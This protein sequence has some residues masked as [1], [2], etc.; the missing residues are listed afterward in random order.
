M[1]N[2]LAIAF[3]FVGVSFEKIYSQNLISNG[4]FE[5]YYSC[6]TATDQVDSVVGWFAVTQ[7]PDYFNSCSA[8]SEVSVPSNVV[9]YQVPVSGK[10]YCGMICYYST[11]N[12]REY[13]GTHL[14]NPLVVGQKYFVSFS[15]NLSGELGFIV[16]CN[17]FGCKLS[18]A[19]FIYNS[20]QPNN[21][22]NF[23]S[24]SII[25]DTANWIFIEGSFIADSSYDYI[26]FGNFF[27]DSHSDTLSLGENTQL[28]Y[29]YIDDVCLS[30]DSL[31]CNLPDDINEIS[32]EDAI[33][34]VPNP[35]TIFF[36][37][38]ATQ[39]INSVRVLNIL[40]QDIYID[41]TAVFPMQ[42]KQIETEQWNKGIYFVELQ[43]GNLVFSKKIIIQ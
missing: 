35:S 16:G 21:E 23:Y 8:I 43:I 15:L 11:P 30:S 29:Y 39:K 33:Q 34:I 2:C 31:S 26:A 13:I 20:I 10:A 22:A 32:S 27:D 41:K 5:E 40:G 7:S 1:K 14:I 37:V 4:S 18:T 17:K 38:S 19:P 28:T 3:L 24:D 42:K 25:T 6:P 9:G 36:T 12:A